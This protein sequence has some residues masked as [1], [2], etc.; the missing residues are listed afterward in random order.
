MDRCVLNKSREIYEEYGIDYDRVS[1][2]GVVN[3]YYEGGY[4]SVLLNTGGVR[5]LEE[6]KI[7]KYSIPRR[8][9]KII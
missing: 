4:M 8:Y 6:G 7:K 2:I 3:G 5:G 9:I 1:L